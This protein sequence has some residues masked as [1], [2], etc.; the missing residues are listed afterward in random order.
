M[1]TL[2]ARGVPPAEVF[3]AVAR[4][5][6]RVLGVDVTHIGCYEPDDTV[7]VVASWNPAGTPIPAGTRASLAGKSVAALVQR[8]GRPARLDSYDD[9]SGSIT[10]MLRDLGIRCSVGAPIV[11]DGR[12]WGV[13]VASSKHQEPL[14]RDTEARIVAFTELVAT[15]ISNAQA[16]VELS[17]L[18]EEQAA[19][20]RVATLVAEGATPA[21]V[22]EA[23]ATEMEG[24]LEAGGVTISRYEPGAEVTVVAHCGPG[25]RRL[26]PGT[27][28][29]H[30]GENLTS[31]VRRTEQPARLEQYEHMRGAVGELVQTLGVRA[32]V[33]TPIAVDG[34][35]WGVIIA[36]WT[37]RRVAAGRRRG[38]DGP[39]RRAARYRDRQRRRP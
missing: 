34:R 5:I 2:V 7:S 21:A 26:P 39:V 6:G 15:A 14:A 3:A 19:L 12:L 30:E 1:A 36:N 20:R 31:I 32:A 29:N 25:A 38:A 35:M 9:A 24:L 4:E 16:H 13:T 17:R 22:F 27:R 8:T 11:V 18:A 37:R 23:V 10:D 33:G 28:V